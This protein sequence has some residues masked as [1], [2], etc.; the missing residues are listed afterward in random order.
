MLQS[1]KI[2]EKVFAVF[3]LTAFFSASST[4]PEGFGAGLP[5]DATVDFQGLGKSRQVEGG[6]PFGFLFCLHASEAGIDRI[7]MKI[8]LPPEVKNLGGETSWKGDLAPKEEA[9]LNLGLKSE[10]GIEKWRQPFQ[11][12]MQFVYQ[13]MKVSRKVKWTGQGLEDTGF[14]STER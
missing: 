8:V 3:F 1:K 7:E 12:Q 4:G 14:V 13:G 5:F 9:C 6:E 2:R 10:T 11:A